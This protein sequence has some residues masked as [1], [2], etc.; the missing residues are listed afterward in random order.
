MRSVLYTI[1]I[2]YLLIFNSFA[3]TY[4]VKSDGN[5]GNTGLS[6]AQAWETISKVN[7]S[8]SGTGDDVYF[9]CG[10]TWTGEYLYNDWNGTVG[11]RVVIGAYY[12]DGGTEVHGISGNKP[13]IDGNH[14]VPTDKYIGL[15]QVNKQG[16]V[17]VENLRLINSEGQGVRF[18]QANNGIASNVDVTNT[19]NSGIQFYVAED[20]IAENCTVTLAGMGWWD[21]LDSD[22]P[23]S[24]GAI[25]NCDNIII[26]NC[27]VYEVHAEGIGFYK[28]SDNC[29]AENNIV[30]AAQKWGIYIDGGIG[31]IVRNNLVY[32]TTNTDFH[33]DPSTAGPGIGV[34]DE[35]WVEAR[36]DNNKFYGN[37]VAFCSVGMYIGCSLDG[38]SFKNSVFY[39]NTFVDCDNSIHISTNVFSNSFIR[40][41]I[42]WQPSG[43]GLYDGPGSTSG[44]TW[45][46]NN[47]TTNP[48]SPTSGT[49][50]VIGSPILT[51]TSGWRLMAGGDLTGN[52]FTLQ[53]SSPA[54]DVGTDLGASYDDGLD[55]DSVWPSS[56]TTLDQDLY[57]A[58]WEI[59]AFVFDFTIY[60]ASPANN[61]TGVS[62]TTDLSW[63]NPTG[64]TNIDLLFDKKSE[65]DPPTTVELND[66]NVETWDCGTLDYSTE[67]AWRVDVNH[68]G[69]TEMGTVY[70]F[71]TTSQA[72][73]PTPSVGM[74]YCPNGV[75]GS[76]CS[77]GVKVQ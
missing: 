22:W 40:N 65:H 4:Y 57:G 72:N 8:I 17:T 12:M 38:A 53:N 21:G 15:I 27:T 70:Y 23:H 29:T 42:F 41:N 2:F 44:L 58:G 28:R 68:A 62:I 36:S 11:D 20:G 49:G 18:Y 74:N 9:K 66:Q 37:I 30:Y 76:Y 33:R 59:G 5:D 26:R 43:G 6:D 77:K 73:P 64:T 60:N 7:N 45:D 16:Y 69:G 67:Y 14:L 48:G 61:D 55:P 52:D 1:I 31:C 63:T 24:M 10:D 34:S 13:V 46:H 32:G 56:V 35:G 47:W 71:T 51:K 50:D 75:A 3:A 25:L 54:I 39:N 19:R